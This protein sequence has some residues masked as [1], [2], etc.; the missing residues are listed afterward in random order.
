[1]T[2]P[3]V[4]LAKIIEAI[5]NRPTTS[6]LELALVEF[7]ELSDSEQKALLFRELVHI[8]SQVNFLMSRF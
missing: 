8:S 1:M 3:K 6:D 7:L 4:T 2:D 5:H